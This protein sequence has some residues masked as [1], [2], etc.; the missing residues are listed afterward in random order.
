MQLKKNWTEILKKE[1]QLPF[2]GGIRYYYFLIVFLIAFYIITNNVLIGIV[3]GLSILLFF[4]F[5]IFEGVGEH[6][7]KN[8]IKELFIA[9]I[10]AAFLWYGLGFLL[11]TPT[12]I[13]A[14]VS[15][16][17]LPAYDRGDLIILSGEKINTN[18]INYDKEIFKEINSEIFAFYEN[19]KLN[20]SEGLFSYC[21]ENQ[22]N[23]LCL[24]FKEKPEKFSEKYGPITINY[25]LCSKMDK[26]TKKYLLKLV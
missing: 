24:K 26:K 13:N 25:G 22:E 4:L 10:L 6:G 7:I 18:Y 14:I 2:I 20:L 3:A 16:S 17:M 19:K 11:K 5:E 21:M 9:L 23:E 8:E 12:P 1:V 15:C